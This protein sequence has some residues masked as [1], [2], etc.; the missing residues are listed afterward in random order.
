MPRS[1]CSILWHTPDKTLGTTFE[2]V[3]VVV[4]VVVVVVVPE[5]RP[6]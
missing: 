3:F 1:R 2:V 4:V 5:K 6:N